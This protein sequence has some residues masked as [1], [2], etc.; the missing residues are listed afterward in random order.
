MNKLEELFNLISKNEPLLTK[1]AYKS[2]WQVGSTLVYPI[3]FWGGNQI[4]IQLTT[5]KNLFTKLLKR[6]EK[7][8]GVKYCYFWKSDGSCPSTITIYT[9]M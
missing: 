8:N 4:V 9:D 7:Y 3:A 6:I 2:T 5:D 1:Y